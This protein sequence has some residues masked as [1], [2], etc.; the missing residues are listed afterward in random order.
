MKPEELEN[1]KKIFVDTLKETGRSGIDNVLV[2]LEELGFFTAP[3]STRFH[4]AEEG[5]LLQHSINVW[6]EAWCIRT[7]QMKIRPDLAELVPESSVAIAALLH[8]VCKAEIY[9]KEKKFRKNEQGRWEDYIGY[10]V[11]YSSFPMGHGEKSV[12][13]L[14]RW[15][16]K[17]TDAEM[18]AIRW[19]MG[20]FNIPFQSSEMGT[21]LTK[22]K[23]RHPLVS[24]ISSADELASYILESR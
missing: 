10:G 5:G 21:C 15:G 13:Q 7:V 23:E 20:A 2:N 3:A 8:D 17:M 9:V 4:G 19:H 22:A 11:D 14:L 6:Q 18:L 12:V 16:L 1:N 24:I